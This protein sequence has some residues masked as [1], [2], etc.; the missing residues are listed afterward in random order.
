MYWQECNA[1]W[2]WVKE[3]VEDSLSMKWP[4]RAGAVISTD[5]GENIFAARIPE[6]RVPFVGE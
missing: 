3:P 6:G 2:D 1:A 4:K 5:Q